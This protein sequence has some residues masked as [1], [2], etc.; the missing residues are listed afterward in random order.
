MSVIEI[1]TFLKLKT[2]RES[3]W[4]FENISKTKITVALVLYD[5]VHYMIFSFVLQ[6]NG[7]SDDIKCYIEGYTKKIFFI[8]LLKP[9]MSF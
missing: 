6:P 7:L 3:K 8:I 4:N 1:S 5:N 9:N 2:N